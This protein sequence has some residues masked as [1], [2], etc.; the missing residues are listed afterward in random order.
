MLCC[1]SLIRVHNL[2][3]VRVTDCPTQLV[4]GLGFSRADSCK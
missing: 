1:D 3:N 2:T 4:E